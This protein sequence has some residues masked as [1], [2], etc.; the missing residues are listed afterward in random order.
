MKINRLI[1]QPDNSWQEIEDDMTEQEELDYYLSAYKDVE[2]RAIAKRS[3]YLTAD[4][5][6]DSPI[7]TMKLA[8]LEAERSEIEAE[9]ADIVSNVIR[10]G[11]ND[12]IEQLI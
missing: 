4:L 5:L 9:Y 8:N 2:E 12:A 6:P 3:E 1:R 7:K 10:I 11:G